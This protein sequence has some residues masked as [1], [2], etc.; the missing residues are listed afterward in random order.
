MVWHTGAS[1][2]TLDTN[3]TAYFVPA[4]LASLKFLKN[5]MKEGCFKPLNFRIVCYLVANN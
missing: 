5:I 1:L 4:S 3:D 2:A